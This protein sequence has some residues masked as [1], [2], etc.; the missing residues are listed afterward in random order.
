MAQ[1]FF[2]DME[3]RKAGAIVDLLKKTLT[4]SC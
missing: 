2:G 1:G 4:E 3:E